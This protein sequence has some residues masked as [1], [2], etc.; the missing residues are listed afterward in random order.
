MGICCYTNPAAAQAAAPN[1]TIQTGVPAQAT[2]QVVMA[3]PAAA[4]QQQIPVVVPQ[5]CMPGS[6]VQVNINGQPMSVAVPQGVAP[7]QQFMVAAPT[8]P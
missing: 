2:A 4:T 7:G 1:I 6:M 5:G 8:Q 3:Q